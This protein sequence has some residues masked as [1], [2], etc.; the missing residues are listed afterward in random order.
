MTCSGNDA[1]TTSPNLSDEGSKTV[2]G[3][4]TM[5]NARPAYELL[6]SLCELGMTCSGNHAVTASPDLSDEGSKTVGGEFTMSNA[7]P[8][9]ELLDSSSELGMTCSGNDAVTAIT[10]RRTGL[11]TRQP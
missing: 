1:V 2:G 5:S 4:F 9:A 3:E 11:R 6:D 10:P 7:R 8:A